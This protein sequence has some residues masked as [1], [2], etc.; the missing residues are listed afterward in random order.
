MP[1]IVRPDEAAAR[2]R[3]GQVVVMQRWPTAAPDRMRAWRG[4]GGAG[5]GRSASPPFFR[6]VELKTYDYPRAPDGRPGVGAP[7][8]RARQHR[9]QQHP[10]PRAAGRPLALAARGPRV[11]SRLP[12]ARAGEGHR[13]RRAVHRA[14][15][16]R[17]FQIDGDDVD[18]RAESDRALASSAARAGN[19]VFTADVTADETA[20]LDQR[21]AVERAPRGPAV[22]GRPGVR[23]AAGRHP[24]LRRTD[25][26]GGGRRP[27]LHDLR[28][29]RP[30]AAHGARSCASATS[31]S[32]RW[33]S[34]RRCWRGPCRWR[35]S[36]ARTE[37]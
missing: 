9:R 6:T 13:L 12:G 17:T 22:R 21:A 8:H 10:A 29:R 30:G 11:S 7:R 2:K 37:R 15:A 27:Q 35:R 14:R 34:P 28:R 31:A 32:R 1:A 24:A 3:K 26:R 20:L 25:R 36:G 4:V 5:L 19:V 23:G 18:R 33:P 16:R